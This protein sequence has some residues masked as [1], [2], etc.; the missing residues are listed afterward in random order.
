MRYR[1]S[2]FVTL[3][4][5]LLLGLVAGCG[6]DT[7]TEKKARPY[8]QEWSGSVEESLR[9]VA[10]APAAKNELQSRLLEASG[11]QTDEGTNGEPP[12]DVY[13]Q[14]AYADNGNKL[15]LVDSSG[16]TERG[17]AAWGA[18]KEVDDH[19]L[20]PGPYQLDTIREKLDKVDSIAKKLDSMERFEP[21]ADLQE[22]AVNWVMSKPRAEFELSEDNY[23][24]VTEA[25]LEEPAGEQMSVRMDKYR[26]L[27]EEL[28]KAE[29]SLEHLLARGV[30]RYAREMRYFR[31]QELF[32]HEREDDPWT[33][34]EIEGR[35]PD[36]ARGAYR[37]GQVWRHAARMANE[38]GEQ[39]EQ[40]IL[41]DKLQATLQAFLTGEEPTKTIAELPPQHPQY[42]KLV[43]E[44]RRYK[45]IVDN[46]GWEEVPERRGLR[47]GSEGEVVAKLKKRLQIE[48][49]YPESAPIDETFGDTLEEAVEA[50]QKTHQMRADGRAH[51]MF[52]SSVN[53]PAERRMKQ[54]ALNL[55]RWRQSDIR[56]SDPR[57]VYVNIPDF[58]VEVWD[59]QK[60]AM[61]FR[62]VVGNNNLKIDEETKEK[63][64]PNRTPSL[65]AYIDRV[66]YNPF[67]NV[68]DRIRAE[69]ILPEVRKQVEGAYKAKLGRL[70]ERAE[71]KKAERESTFIS[72]GIF[73]GGD[74]GSSNASNDSSTE[75][76]TSGDA[77]ATEATANT[78][79]S[80]DDPQAGGDDVEKKPAPPKS[81][82]GK[83]LTK[84]P[85][86]KQL[87]FRVGA[88]RSLLSEVYGSSSDA[89]AAESGSSGSDASKSGGDG[90]STSLLAAH[91]PYINP[92][93]GVVD[94]S[95]TDPDNIPAWYEANKY[96]VMFPG[97]KWEY[98][99]MKQG[100]SNALGKVKVIFPNLHDVYLHDTPKKALFSRDIRAFSHGC[101]RM[102]KPLSFAE[103]LLKRDGQLDDYNI[104]RILRETTYKP[105]FLKRQIPVHV[106]YKTVRVGDEG[107]AHFLADIYDYDKE[108]LAE[109]DG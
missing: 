69:E 88:V 107:R 54:I 6:E 37:G 38:I 23:S 100:D 19:A 98:V 66:I 4:S 55:E 106:E 59:E 78:D 61:R 63:E 47:N 21:D 56:H 29:A 35:R 14:K 62:I 42:A 30:A 73:G 103:Y 85:E 67:W 76:D 74:E 53:I 18:I 48:G 83:Y 13:L 102:H 99:R 7:V 27:A 28:G 45:K 15:V 87:A 96:E 17:Q 109:S 70:V 89:A 39:N 90:E 72:G 32:V 5:V 24:A 84:G 108:A 8:V 64:H 91:F 97:K 93:T 36:E 71:K 94:V 68:T 86:G 95:K 20:D 105:I 31:L 104:D 10:F 101:M 57:Y 49:Y 9:D 82:I 51:S 44:Y 50:Y 77:S 25:M 41:R 80:Q 33:D 81:S 43:D 65:S 1:Q 79:A 3:L 12:Y 22:S 52:W 16:L 60:R 26:A 2:T 40:E 75:S 34:P 46:G 92:E 58:H 11:E